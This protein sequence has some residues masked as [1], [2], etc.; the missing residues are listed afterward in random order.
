MDPS[1][2][3]SGLE[4]FLHYAADINSKTTSGKTPPGCAARG[5]YIATVELLLAH[6]AHIDSLLGYSNKSTNAITQSSY[7][8]S[9]TM[10]KMLLKRGADVNFR[11]A[12]EHGG[13][14]LHIVATNRHMRCQTPNI[15]LLL[16]YGADLEAKDDVGKTP[17]AA[18]V[19][20]YTLEVIPILLA[21]GADLE[22][23]DYLG[24]MPLGAAIRKRNFEA[25]HIFLREEPI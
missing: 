1:C 4:L 17:L 20:A 12:E 21:R 23:R 11:D 24:E 16:E 8:R 9:T 10:V 14:L 3:I 22:A 7:G 25:V 18:A 6:G 2:S 15:R 19:E 5:G 13:T